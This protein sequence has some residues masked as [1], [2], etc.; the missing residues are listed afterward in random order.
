MFVYLEGVPEAQFHKKKSKQVQIQIK[1]RRIQFTCN[2]IFEKVL[3][4]FVMLQLNIVCH[5]CCE[6]TCEVEKYIVTYL[7]L[8]TDN[9]GGGDNLR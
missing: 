5:Q 2:C 4:T 1:S 9:F 8:T 6:D 3:H 7:V